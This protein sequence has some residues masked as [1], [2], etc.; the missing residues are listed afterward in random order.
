[1]STWQV[2]ALFV[3]AGCLIVSL[4]GICLGIGKLTRG[5][6]SI[7]AEITKMNAKIDRI[8]ATSGDRSSKQ[9]EQCAPDSSF[10]DIE[11][12]ISNFE[13]LKRIDVTRPE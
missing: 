9:K 8:E 1:M 5:I 11:A 13:K 7:A 3:T 6:L 10:E 2:I 4:V 12:A